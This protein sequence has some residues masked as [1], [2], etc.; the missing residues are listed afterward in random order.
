M[1]APLSNTTSGFSRRRA[2]AGVLGA[3]SLL[4]AG[5]GE[6]APGSIGTNGGSGCNGCGNQARC[7]CR[8]CTFR[9]QGQG[10]IHDPG[11]R[12]C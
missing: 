9:R 5:G 1:T 10:R 4:A 2:L 3:G 6:A 12:P 8:P 7:D 11:N